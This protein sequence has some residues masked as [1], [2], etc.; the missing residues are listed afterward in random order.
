MKILV[1]IREKLNG[2]L[3]YREVVPH[4]YMAGQHDVK[5]M[6]RDNIFTMSDEE[7]EE[8]DIIHSSYF[9]IDE[10]SLKRIH[11]LD[12][13][14]VID[15]DDYWILDRFHELYE[16]YQEENR[17]D[18][19]RVLMDNADAVTTT[20]EL[21]AQKIRPHAKSV[22]VFGNTLMDD[23]YSMPK[24]NPIPFV[25]WLGA[26]NHTAD[27]MEIQHLQ[28]GYG[29]PVYIPELYRQVFKDRFLYYQGQEV[30]QYLGLYNEYDIIISPLRDNVFNKHKSP[31]K[32]IEAGFF[33][34]PLIISDVE[35]FSPYLEHKKN[36]LV[37][38]K[39]SEWKKWC[40]LLIDNP[41]MG[42]QLGENLH[43]TV[44]DNFDINRITKERFAYY[45]SLI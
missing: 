44:I 20:T 13:K 27:L 14:L 6:F 12:V 35:P 40:N 17:A 41:D 24:K 28:K 10:M 25:G 39:K 16:Y 3:F 18:W 37:V 21:L 29:I 31:L 26:G 19:I 4:S 38:R 34:K 32:L 9:F 23:D 36:C 33:K 7:I 5:V 30:P 8:Y 15:I 43:K 42:K 22:G 2:V 1:L 11:N 45:E